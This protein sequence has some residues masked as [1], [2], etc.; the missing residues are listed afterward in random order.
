MGVR[1][2]YEC[3]CI[4]VDVGA[5][6]RCEEHKKLVRTQWSTSLPVGVNRKIHRRDNITL[7]LGDLHES[8]AKIPTESIGLICSYPNQSEFYARK[9][10]DFLR[11]PDTFFRHYMRVLRQ[12]GLLMLFIEPTLIDAAIYTASRCNF[13]VNSVS[14]VML[15]VSP[16]N[17]YHIAADFTKFCLLLSKPDGNDLTI[18]NF[19]LKSDTK[20]FE[21]LKIKGTVLDVSCVVRAI[22][23]NSV[24][25]NKTIGL[26]YE[27]EIYKS[28]VTHFR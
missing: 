25:T 10:T 1:S 2:V 13:S 9:D 11:M 3:G 4:D 8:L 19:K 7:V 26:C 17:S 27:P 18:S 12:D 6:A 22:V 21:H 15:K 14:Q 5:V 23:T 28:L 16:C 24:R 20:L